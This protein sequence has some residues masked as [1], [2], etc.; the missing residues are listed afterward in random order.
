VLLTLT[1]VYEDVDEDTTYTEPTTFRV[2]YMKASESTVSI[3]TSVGPGTVYAYGI[4]VRWKSGDNL[5][6]VHH[7][8]LSTGAKAGIGIGITL[9]VLLVGMLFGPVFDAAVA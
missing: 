3:T 8:S 6:T 2:T 1:T 5:E 7:S 4:Q 9:V